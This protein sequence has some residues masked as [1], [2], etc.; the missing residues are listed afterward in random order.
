MLFLIF[1][2]ILFLMVRYE[3]SGG[4]ELILRAARVREY[5]LGALAGS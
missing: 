4:T 5:P 3:K 2:L 1:I